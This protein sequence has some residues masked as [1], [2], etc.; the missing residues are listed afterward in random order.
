MEAKGGQPLPIVLVPGLNCPA[1]L[2]AEQIP[3]LWRS[4]GPVADHT[5]D[6]S[7]EAIASA[8]LPRRRP[9]CARR[10]LDGRLH[11][12]STILRQAPERVA[13]LAL[14]DTRRGRNAGADRAAQAADRARAG[15]P[16]R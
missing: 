4:G 13:K 14:L 9:L 16:L 3:S 5:R 6:D 7:M 8:S 1:R 10:A 15:G 12:A 11:R 2:Y